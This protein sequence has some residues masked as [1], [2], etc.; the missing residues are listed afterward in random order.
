MIEQTRTR[1]LAAARPPRRTTLWDVGLEFLSHADN[2][3]FVAPALA[4]AAG[5]LG[6]GP[7]GADLL[8]LAC[9][10]LIF[11]PQEYFTH[12]HL[13]HAPLP[14]RRRV[15][16][17]FYRLHYGHHDT[18]RRHDLMYMPLWLTL[19]MLAANVALLWWLTPAPRAFWAAFGGALVGYIVFEWS[20][21]L[22]HVPCVPRSRLWR[23]VRT[24]HLLHHFSDEQR[25]YAVAPWSL[26][27]DRL[28]GTRTAEGQAPR[29][30]NCR[31][32]GLDAHHPWLAEARAQFAAASNGDAT[33]SR[34]WQRGGPRALGESQ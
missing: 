26:V 15:Y 12:V 11:I 17:W 27:M 22:C 25:G 19:P 9:G 30:P 2:W 32:L 5:L 23:H 14:K 10:V 7:G 34:L 6:T 33:G 21:L 18:P 29:S 4:I 24:Q 16:L 1:P 3:V 8:W 13:L 20:H 31:F 28:M